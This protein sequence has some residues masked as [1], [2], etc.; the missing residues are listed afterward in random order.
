MSAVHIFAV[1]PRNSSALTPWGMYTGAA[2]EIHGNNLSAQAIYFWQ[3][4]ED[5]VVGKHYAGISLKA[6]LVIGITSNVLYSYT[7]INGKDTNLIEG[8]AASAGVDYSF[9][10]S[11]HTLYLLAE[12]LYNGENSAT[13]QGERNLYGYKTHHHI[14]GSARFS[15]TDL[16]SATAGA[17]VS[18]DNGKT[19]LIAIYAADLF[20]GANLSVQ[21]NVPLN[22]AANP[23]RADFSIKLSFRI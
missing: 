6:D 19:A 9:S 5:D 14:Y 15:I 4:I 11:T 3:P 16:S 18:A 17:L 23:T 1:L 22:D 20:Q 8:L 21:A 10:I 13:A 7:A 2:G 12:Y